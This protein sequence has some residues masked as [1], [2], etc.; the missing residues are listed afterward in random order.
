MTAHPKT[1]APPAPL[2]PAAV[3]SY[4]SV[5]AR[6]PKPPLPEDILFKLR[7]AIQAVP[8][9]RPRVRGAEYA[10]APDGARVKTRP[11]HAWTPAET[12]RFE[13]SV[14]WLLKGARVMPAKGSLG[15]HI[16]FYGTGLEGCDVDNLSKSILDAGNGLAWIDDRQVTLLTTEVVHD[17]DCACI[18]IVAYRRTAGRRAA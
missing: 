12:A 15:V 7:L 10:V 11:G 1:A 17:S 8:K 14:G 4:S 16:V 6:W 5:L 3:M 13:E 18:E 9:Q 2:S